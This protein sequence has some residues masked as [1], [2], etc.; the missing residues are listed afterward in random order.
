MERLNI[1]QL[2][3]WIDSQ[4]SDVERTIIRNRKDEKIVRMR[5]R[6]KDEQIILDKLCIKRWKEAEKEGKI[7]YITD[8]KWYYDFD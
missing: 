3:K 1:N 6:D 7:K 8:R 4:K 2:N 5:E